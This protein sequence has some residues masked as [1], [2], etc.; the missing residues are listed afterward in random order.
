M[1]Q[2]VNKRI[3][4]FVL[5]AIMLISTVAATLTAYAV[6]G[7]KKTEVTAAET[8]ESDFSSKR[9][10]VMTDDASVIQGKGSVIG[11]YG[12]VYLLQFETA[13]ETM[14]AYASLKDK[15][16]AVEPDIV[17]EAASTNKGSD[18]QINETENPV[19]ALNGLGDAKAAK[20]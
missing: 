8:K 3:T 20:K 16:T 9:L 1:F 14:E 10:I 17:V 5:F 18:I 19:E 15:V 7:E 4:A 13:K 2:K 6:S 11:E 12:E